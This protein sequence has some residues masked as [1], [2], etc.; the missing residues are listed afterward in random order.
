VDSSLLALENV[1]YEYAESE[2]R[3]HPL[4]CSIRAGD[5]VGIVGPNGSGKSTLLRIAAGV[6]SPLSGRVLLT[7][8]HVT[9]LARR[10]IARSLGYL[11]QQIAASYDYSV[12]EVVAMGRF[13][14]LAAASFLEDS[15]LEVIERCLEVTETASYRFR[16]L[17]HLS[18]GE[19]QRVFLA[20][21]LAQEP[22]V[23]LLDE[24]T[25]A[26]DIHHQ[27]SFFRLLTDLAGRGMGVAVVTHD[28]N[29]ASLF[30]SRLLLLAG[31]RLV[32]EG[33]PE[34]VMSAEALSSVYGEV[35]YIARHQAT[36]RPMVY[37]T[38]AEG[39]AEQG[40]EE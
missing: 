23:L 9:S 21:V 1:S 31:G 20:S 38:I 16:R 14:H 22:K 30:C 27:V 3:L 40:G 12:E 5:V 15:D 32:K 37:P 39:P 7:G 19:R 18:G 33:T 26:L 34:T 2:W 6:L 17:S 10:Q 28:L 24:P 25:S 35:L 8:R 36:G 29:L 4:T 11:P 13:P